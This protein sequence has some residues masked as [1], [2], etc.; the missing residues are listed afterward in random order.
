VVEQRVDRD[1]VAVHD[2]EDAVGQAGLLPQL[3][4]EERRRRVLLGRL[5]HERVAAG[6]R[7][8]EHPHRHHRR[9][10]ERRDAG[11]DA[12]RLADRVDVDAGRDLLGELALEQVR[13]AAGELD[14]LE[15]ALTSPSASESTLP[16]SAAASIRVPDSRAWSSQPKTQ[17]VRTPSKPIPARAAKA[18]S[19][20]TS[21]R[22][23]S[24]C[25]CTRTGVARRVGDV[26]QPV[27]GGVV[28][29]VGDVH[30]GEQVTGV[31]R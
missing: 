2:V 24:M 21:P 15:A 9:E 10:V 31:R 19:K 30:V 17:V 23:I 22:P 20:S 14:D 4:D 26:A 16:C 7:D 12:E 25:W 27:G 8:R 28:H 11:D 3:G 13:D 5:E 18:S 1:L 6:D 29:R